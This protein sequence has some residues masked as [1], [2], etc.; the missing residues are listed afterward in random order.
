MA[1]PLLQLLSRPDLLQVTRQ[2]QLLMDN[3]HPVVVRN[4]GADEKIG[5]MDRPGL[6]RQTEG[7]IAVPVQIVRLAID[8]FRPVLADVGP[9]ILSAEVPAIVFQVFRSVALPDQFRSYGGV[10]RPLVRVVP[11]AW[12]MQGL[13]ARRLTRRCGPVQIAHADLQDV[14]VPAALPLQVLARIDLLRS[15]LVA[16]CL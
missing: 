6:S 4:F 8:G 2:G 12:T 5:P 13:N 1:A 9:I 3:G 14:F 11:P 7:E 16:G 10:A 15:W